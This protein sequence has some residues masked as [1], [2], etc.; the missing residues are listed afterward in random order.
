MVL[1]QTRGNVI[2]FIQ[3]INYLSIE[4]RITPQK[5]M[6]HCFKRC[7][8]FNYVHKFDQKHYKGNP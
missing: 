1:S 5:K 2:W 3:L 6:F 4:L 7:I 8:T